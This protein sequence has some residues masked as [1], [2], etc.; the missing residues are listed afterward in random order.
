MVLLNSVCEMELKKMV[1]LA[2]GL[3]DTKH[4][5]WEELGFFWGVSHS[6]SVVKMYLGLKMCKRVNFNVC[7]IS[8]VLHSTRI[9]HS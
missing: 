5:L 3:E 8:P 1:N 2:Q 6:Q 9:D 7:I 4:E